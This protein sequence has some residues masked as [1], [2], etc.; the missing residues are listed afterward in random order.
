MT[1]YQRLVSFDRALRVALLLRH[2]S[3]VKQFLGVAVHLLLAR[4]DIFHFLARLENDR[5]AAPLRKKQTNR[6]T[7]KRRETSQFHGASQG[8]EVLG[9]VK[10]PKPWSKGVMD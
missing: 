2:L 6:Q 1:A 3:D 8:N 7:N 10:L 4:W 5:S 9:S